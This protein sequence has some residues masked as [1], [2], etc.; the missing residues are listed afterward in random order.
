[1]FCPKCGSKALDGATFCQKC[2]AN[3]IVDD[4]V[5]HSVTSTPIQQTQQQTH[6]VPSDMPKKKK[7]GKLP[8]I[9]GAVALAI[10]VIIVIAMNWNGKMDYEATVRAHQPFA[11]TQG[12]SYT[13]G[14]V[15]DKYISSPDWE[16]RKSGDVNYVDISGKAKGT[17]NELV[18]TIKVAEDPSDPDLAKIAPESVIIDGKKSPTQNDAVEFLLAMFLMYEEGYD[19]ISDLFSETGIPAGTKTMV[20]ETK[21]YDNNFGNMEVTLDYVEFTDRTENTLLGGYIFPDEG[22]IF[23]RATFTLKNV[24]T[25]KGSLITAWN[26][27]V[28]DG[29][30]EFSD[31]FVEGNL[32]DINPLSAPTTGSI[33]FTVP[34]D[35]AESDKPLVININ[36][37]SGEAVITY[38][39]RPAGGTSGEDEVSADKT[40]L[41][42]V[43]SMED[44][45]NLVENWMID[46]PIEAE[47]TIDPGA[48]AN[49][50]E[51]IRAEYYVTVLWGSPKDALG[52]VYVRKTDGYM[53]FQD[54]NGKELIDLDEWY[55]ALLAAAF[56]ADTNS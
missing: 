32:T 26:T 10:V 24:G 17:D 44:A 39:L 38:V 50:I 42:S 12:L 20:G 19:D 8:I 30:Y 5:Q 56:E 27:V 21:S 2:G 25:E 35:V 3:L 23:L 18:I 52:F 37:G 47:A 45:V 34:N 46:H 13:Y 9:L 48:P 36:D 53:T 40:N 28:Y 31:S 15:L 29:E 55:K 16:V 43:N 22:S 54:V 7:L 41:D 1:M 51:S 14:E 6:T 33:I 4:T 11:A 49:D